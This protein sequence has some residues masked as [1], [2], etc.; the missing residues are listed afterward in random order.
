[1]TQDQAFKILNSG[2]NVFLTGR[3]GTGKSYLLNKFIEHSEKIKNKNVAVTASTGISA[4]HINGTTIH[5]WSGIGITKE[6]EWN[7]IKLSSIITNNRIV[8]RIQNT[9][10]LIIDEISMIHA[11]QL[12][13]VHEI[14]SII[15]GKD[16]PFGG[17]QTIIVGD[18]N[19]LP[20][21]G[22]NA[23]YVFDSKIW[24]EADLK[25]CYLTHNYR[26]DDPIF[27]DILNEV[28]QGVFKQSSFDI[29]ESCI[30]KRLTIS[31]PTELYSKNIDVD[32]INSKK[33][34]LID[35]PSKF[36]KMVEVG[37][38]YAI[39]NLKKNCLSPEKLEVKEGAL[40]M[41]TKNNYELGYI[42]G[43]QGK[44]IGY[45][46]IGIPIVETLDGRQIEPT[47][48]KWE[49]QD[50]NPKTGKYEVIAKIVQLPLKL[51]FAITIHKSQGCTMDFAKMN[52]SN[53]FAHNMGYVALSRVKSLEGLTLMALD[54]SIYLVDPLIL[55]K[56]L[57]FQQESLQLVSTLNN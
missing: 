27:I 37:K 45:N 16:L 17:I 19:Q 29:L 38:E 41:F 11:Y 5:S 57:E 22:N 4:T 24:K 53:M 35:Q 21:V 6:E 13:A 1:M 40:V 8:E 15:K 48:E 14:L 50:I 33:L 46:K 10:I 39:K 44:I 52:L 42:N 43:T 31:N 2:A 56:D 51:A 28:R 34:A 55:Q 7:P 36:Y 20:A 9:D 32:L 3:A 12:Y 25:V 18:M 54:K 23:K 49:A 30:K 47:Y 26:Q